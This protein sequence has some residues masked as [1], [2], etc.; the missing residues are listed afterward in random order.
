[1]LKFRQ[2]CIK[3]ILA[4]DMAQHNNDL[5][6]I[7]NI[8]DLNTDPNG[9]INYGNVLTESNKLM[10]MKEMIHICDISSPMKSPK[11]SYIWGQRCVIEFFYQ[12]DK[13]KKFG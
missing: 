3:L 5:I 1:M 2:V 13:E 4:T 11:M 6:E 9:V 12:G 10:I 7:K 8:L